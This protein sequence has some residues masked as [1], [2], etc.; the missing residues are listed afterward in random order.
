MV[1]M[2]HDFCLTQGFEENDIEAGEDEGENEDESPKN[3]MWKRTNKSSGS[4]RKKFPH[5]SVKMKCPVCKILVSKQISSLRQN[6][7]H[8]KRLDLWRMS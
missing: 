3:D 6:L 5:S 2:L 4:S 1:R 7:L 8:L